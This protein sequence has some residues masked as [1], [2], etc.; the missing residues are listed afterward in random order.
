MIKKINLLYCIFII[1]GV[2]AGVMGA[3]I[4]DALFLMSIVGYAGYLKWLESKEIPDYKQIFQEE[5]NQ[6]NNKVSGIIIKETKPNQPMQNKRF[7]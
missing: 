1:M 3:S 5:L 2:R 6:L 7:F 4:G